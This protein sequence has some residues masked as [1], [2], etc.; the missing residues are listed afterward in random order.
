MHL[1]NTLCALLSAWALACSMLPH[2]AAAGEENHVTHLDG[3]FI[4]PWLYMTYDDAQW[5]AEMQAMKD[6]GIQYLI[7][8]DVANHNADGSW[9]VYYPSELDFLSG[10][11]VYD[12]LEPILFYCDKYDIKLYLGMGLDCAWNSDIA[13]E[14]GREANRKYME[15][16]N[17]ITAELYN[18]YKASYPDTYYGFY[19]VTELYNT[20][21]MDTDTGIDAYAEGLEEMFTLVLEQCN[22]L[23][24]SMPLLFSPYVNIFGYGYASINPDRFAEYWTEVLTRIPFRDGD[25]LCPQDSCGGGGMD[26]A[27]LAQWTAAYR[28]AVDRAN[29]K[30]G[31]RLL[32]G[33]NAEMF[34]QPD[35]ARMQSPHGVSYTGI[36]T[37]RDFTQRLEIADP[38]VDALFCFAYPH[39]YSPYNTLPE[40][41]QC[42]LEYLKTGT[43]ETEPPTPPVRVDMTLVEQE[44]SNHPQFT[45]SGM[46]DNTAVAQINLYKNGTLYDY[47]VPSVKVGGNASQ[48]VWVDYDYTEG[49]QVYEVECID[50]CGNVSEKRSFTVDVS[51]LTQGNTQQLTTEAPIQWNKTSLDYLRYTV[52]ESGVR[53]TGCEK[54]A[55]EIEIPAQI[56]GKPVTVVDWYAFER[57]AKL[58]SV[59][60]P[61]TVTHISRF[62]FAHCI[63]LETVNLPTSLYAI[64]QY[65]FFDCPRLQGLRLP[66]HLTIIEERAFC[67]CDA[68]TDI[69]IPESCTSV[70]DYAFL[71]C[72]SLYRVGI[73]GDAQ[74]GLRS[75]G[76]RYRSGYQLQPGFV[77]D[78][79]SPA[80]ISYGKENGIRMQS[81]L[82]PGDVNGDGQLNVA[83]VVLLQRWL[84][85]VPDTMLADWQAG[86]LCRDGLLNGADL[87]AVKAILVQE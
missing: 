56:E 72:D 74:L 42:F 28:D 76:Y 12:A 65:A 25:M 4:Q 15:Q 35:A 13:S 54:D 70:G 22:Q 44:G 41:H 26:P 43:I 64:E 75:F 57:C 9:T 61:D 29:A 19:F 5:D 21:Y 16:C 78:S 46:T 83:D 67:G 58:R 33:T 66:E 51:S 23:D 7:M 34:V 38:Y 14:A 47:I 79:D 62:A 24:P 37:V 20:I 30:R 48:N 86:D 36:K 11:T 69:T 31:T 73:Q 77:I 17:Q 50:V 10:Y 18:K 87:A 40:F 63:S 53:I 49:E 39:H 55:E 6:T 3:T 27:H 68:I 71:D 8:G 84:L 59:V 82:V 80:A 81:E 32:L 52:T 45:F 85:A 60:I 2:A 1:R